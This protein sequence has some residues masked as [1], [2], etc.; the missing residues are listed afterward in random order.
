MARIIKVVLTVLLA[1][2][3]MG[4]SERYL[5]AEWGLYVKVIIVMIAAVAITLEI[6]TAVGNKKDDG[7]EEE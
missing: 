3:G 6:L 7:G 2:V 4:I 5:G 1:M